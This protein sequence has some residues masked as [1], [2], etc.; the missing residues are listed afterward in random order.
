MDAPIEL[1]P[2]LCVKC[3]SPVPAEIAEV[4]WV[5]QSCGQG[6]LLDDTIGL[7]P[8][9]VNYSAGIPQGSTG[10]PYWVVQGQAS[11]QREQ[12]S[13]DQNAQAQLMWAQPRQFI[14]PAYTCMFDLLLQQG[15]RYLKTPPLLQPGPAVPFVP[16]TLPPADIQALAEFIVV[17]IEAER[18]DMLKKIA[19]SVRLGEPELWILA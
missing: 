8:L 3:Q 14:I 19:V 12:F 7:V 16:V 4:A 9:K 1:L 15:P 11:L 5:C 10:K 17:A 18:S 13:G 6:L 2:L